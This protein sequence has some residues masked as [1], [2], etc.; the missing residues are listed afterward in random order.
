VFP[1]TFTTLHTS[2]RFIA[3]TAKQPMAFSQ[4]LADM[5]QKWI[6]AFKLPTCHAACETGI[7][8]ALTIKPTM[9]TTQTG[10]LASEM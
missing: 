5:R 2:Q 3:L 10:I 1:Q 6:N 8:M 9:L 7:L 4:T